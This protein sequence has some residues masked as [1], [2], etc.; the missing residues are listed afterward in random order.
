MTKTFIIAEAGI[1]FNADMKMA[2]EMIRVANDCGADCVKF[3]TGLPNLVMTPW[4]SRAKY[5]EVNTNSKGTQLDL[6]KNVSMPYENFSILKDLCES[7]G[8]EFMSTAFEMPAARYLNS[9]GMRQFKIASG[10]INNLPYLRL[11]ASFG[12]P[13]ILST[14]MSN[15]DEISEAIEILKKGGMKL[16]ALSILHCTTEYPAPF[17]EVDLKTIG[18]MRSRYGVPIGYSDHTVGIE[19]SIAAVALGATIIE[20]HFTLDRSLPGP[21]QKA[22]IEPNELRQMVASIRNIELACSGD[23]KKYAKPSEQKNIAIARRSIVA[24][25]DIKEGELLTEDNIIPKRPGTG[26]SPMLWDQVVGTM[27][28][29]SFAQDELISIV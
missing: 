16:G 28:V 15:D 14:G 23:G 25:R 3:Q 7:I 18:V 26:L 12:R 5:Q 19:A 1:N 21:D 11:I 20:K 2:A 8:I 9:I 4:A 22:S 6:V 24:A 27:A 13:I 10:E 17:A 29:R